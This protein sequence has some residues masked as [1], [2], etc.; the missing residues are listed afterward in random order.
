MIRIDGNETGRPRNA[1]RAHPVVGK[2]KGID[3]D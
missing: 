3:H 2:S 1:S